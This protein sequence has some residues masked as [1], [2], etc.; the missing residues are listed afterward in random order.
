M[1]RWVPDDESASDGLRY[2]EDS[3]RTRDVLPMKEEKNWK[4]SLCPYLGQRSDPGTALSYPSVLNHCYHAKSVAAIDLGHQEGFC[5][6]TIYPNCKEYATDPNAAL[7]VAL[8]GSSGSRSRKTPGNKKWVLGMIVLG[9]VLVGFGIIV[10]WQFISHG[11]GFQQFFGGPNGSIES[12]GTSTEFTYTFTLP[13]NTSTPTPVPTFVETATSRPPFGLE[14][15]LGIDHKFEIHQVQEGESLELISGKHGTTVAAL[16]ACNY[17]LP[18]PLLPGR[19]IVVPL[20]FVDTQGLP[21]FEAYNV[22]E[23]I[24]LEDLVI[25]LSTDL[26]E[27]KYYNAI[28]DGFIPIIGDWF[29]VPRA[30]LPTP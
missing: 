8:H 3:Q 4:N 30:G 28:G 16:R 23:K 20:N 29:L 25:L 14:T 21:A 9:L 18:S 22:I 24:S 1:A 15:P 27:F 12:T 10:A 19:V 5:L 11:Q 26:N 2:P 17:R 6:T 13:T 7:P